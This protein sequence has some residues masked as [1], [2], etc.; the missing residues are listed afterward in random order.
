MR[1]LHDWMDLVL[2]GRL[3]IEELQP[4]LAIECGIRSRQ[5]CKLMRVGG[6]MKWPKVLPAL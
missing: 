1:M 4:M 2:D 6:R 5:S 3:M